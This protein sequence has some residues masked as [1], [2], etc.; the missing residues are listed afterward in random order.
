MSR[1]V[2]APD[3]RRQELIE[4]ALKQFIE[5]GYEK[6]SVRSILQEAGGEIGMFYH[7]FKSKN[8]IYEAALEKYNEKYLASFTQ[9][10]NF[11]NLSFEQKLNQIFTLLANSLSEYGQNHSEKINPEIKT[12]L[13]SRTLLKIAPLFEQIIVDGV[14]NNILNAPIP[15]LH[16]LSQFILFGI[17]AV[18][19]DNEVKSMEDKVSHIKALLSKLLGIKLGRV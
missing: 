6:T 19:H 18:I 4:I 10:S 14:Q 2:K 1:I 15:N 17:S 8:E 3:E 16:L 13:H 9:I 7:Y 12:L 5:N 11:P